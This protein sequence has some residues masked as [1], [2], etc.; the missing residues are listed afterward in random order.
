MISYLDTRYFAGKVHEKL[1][2]DFFVQL[3]KK[4]IY[5]TFNIYETQTIFTRLNLIWSG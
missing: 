3:F 4:I 2:E 5:V 1:R